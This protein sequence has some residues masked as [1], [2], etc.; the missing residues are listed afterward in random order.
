MNRMEHAAVIFGSI[1]AVCLLIAVASPAE[2]A[3]LGIALVGVCCVAPLTVLRDRRAFALG[4]LAGLAYSAAHVAETMP[5]GPRAGSTLRT[6]LPVALAIPV[7][8][9]VTFAVDQFRVRVVEHEPPAVLPVLSIVQEGEAVEVKQ[10]GHGIE[11]VQRWILF[12]DRYGTSLSVALVGTDVTPGA[13]DEERMRA[14]GEYLTK[15]VRETDSV[16]V[17]DDN[18]FLVTLPHTIRDEANAMMLRLARNAIDEAGRVVRGS[19]VEYPKDG[20]DIDALLRA[21]E[22]GLAFIRAE[23]LPVANEVQASE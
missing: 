20:A 15:S 13:D 8:T 3:L 5:G 6:W 21:A 23:G 9:A 22:A 4:A 16:S 14:V 18:T 2:V 7:Y 19:C 1:A 17:Y 11:D 10:R 12:A